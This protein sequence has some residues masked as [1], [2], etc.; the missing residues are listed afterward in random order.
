VTT[1]HQP[2]R[3]VGELLRRWRGRRR[4]SQFELAL[5]LGISARRLSFVENGRSE[6]RHGPPSLRGA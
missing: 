6:P 4:L 2:R 5:E 3:P 1:A